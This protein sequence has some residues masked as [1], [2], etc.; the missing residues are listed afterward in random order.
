MEL[1]ELREKIDKTNQ[2]EILNRKYNINSELKLVTLTE[3]M[4]VRKYHVES[5]LAEL[6]SKLGGGQYDGKLR[7]NTTIN[8]KVSREGK[9]NAI[10]GLD[11]VDGALALPTKSKEIIKQIKKSMNS[12]SKSRPGTL[13]HRRVPTPVHCLSFI[14]GHYKMAWRNMDR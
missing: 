1:F 8:N 5:S 10:F 13:M 12:E 7:Q 9:R 2:I 3:F 14:K 4:T 11:S 6:C